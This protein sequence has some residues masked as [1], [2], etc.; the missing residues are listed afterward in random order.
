LSPP[1]GCSFGLTAPTEAS[2]VGETGHLLAVCSPALCVGAAGIPLATKAPM[3]QWLRVFPRPRQ[4]LRAPRAVYFTYF[5]FVLWTI[6]AGS[7]SPP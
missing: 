7:R 2:I 5:V 4:Y 3:P 1:A 6:V